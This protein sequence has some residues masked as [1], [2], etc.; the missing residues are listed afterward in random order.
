MKSDVYFMRPTR[1]DLPANP[2]HEILLTI[3]E[4]LK[5]AGYEL[6][7]SSEDSYAFEQTKKG[8]LEGGITR[9][10]N[11][12]LLRE[13]VLPDNTPR[14]EL[15]DLMRYMVRNI[16]ATVELLIIDPYIFPSNPDADYINYLGKVFGT[17]IGNIA[18][19]EIVTKPSR[20]LITEAAFLTMVSGVKP[21]VTRRIKYTNDFHDRFWIADGAR[22]VFV[23]T[24]L[25]GIGRRYS[26]ADYI[27][28]QDVK[29]IYARF[30][31]LP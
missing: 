14:E 21:T 6:C 25:N 3:H 1:D 30:Q 26:I 24:S 15:L 29:D 19:I 17:A 18:R 31:T 27:R 20:D 12:Q 11:S 22:G 13:S 28:E 10:T 23:G 16:Q 5:A 2:S 9:Y 7:L 8:I 4:M